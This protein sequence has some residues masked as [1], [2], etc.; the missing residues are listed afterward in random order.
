MRGDIS[1]TDHEKPCG[2]LYG[3]LKKWIIIEG[4]EQRRPV[5]NIYEK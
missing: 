1:H 5:I 3:T 2:L 4:F